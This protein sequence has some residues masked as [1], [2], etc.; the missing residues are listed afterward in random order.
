MIRLPDGDVSAEALAQLRVYQAE[1][2]DAGAYA[3]RVTR[4]AESFHSANRKGNPTFDAV[5]RALS[6]MCYGAQRCAYCEDSAADEVEHIQPK[7]LYPELVFA[8][9]NYLYACGPCNT[10]KNDKFAIF[11]DGT[12]GV[13]EVTRKR[14]APINP[15]VSGS[16]VFL[17]PRVEDAIRW[18]TLDLRGTFHFVAT[19]TK[20]SRAYERAHYTIETLKLNRDLL[21]EARKQAFKDYV[22]LLKHYVSAKR[23]GE[24][25]EAL[26]DLRCTIVR[27]QHPTVWREMQR[28]HDKHAGLSSLFRDAAEA[29]S[30]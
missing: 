4:A 12:S 11:P 23:G 22:A 16:P 13:L 29:L 1:V 8:W 20:G 17:N 10:A 15:P 7:S 18:I 25:P 30:W 26:D 6:A 19:A 27:R 28:Q 2:D 9:V 14:N 5:K 3:D 24:G 21:V